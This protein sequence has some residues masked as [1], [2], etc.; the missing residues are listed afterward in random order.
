MKQKSKRVQGRKSLLLFVFLAVLMVSMS[1]PALA[2]SYILTWNLVDTGYHLDYDGNSSYMSYI[3]TGASTWNAYK[4]GVIRPDSILNI[5]DVYVSD[6]NAA[7][8]WAAMTYS[9]GKIEM[10]TYY[11]SNYSTSKKTNVATHELGH[12]LGLAHSTSSDV[13][14]ASIT[15]HTSTQALSQNDKDSYDAAYL[16]YGSY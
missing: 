3:T 9:N 1:I 10:N 2:T 13:M 6:V 15:N 16:K 8:G 7:N 4:S 11:L 14:D 5:Q 12:A